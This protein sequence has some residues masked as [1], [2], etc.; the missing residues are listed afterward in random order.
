MSPTLDGICTVSQNVP[1]GLTVSIVKCVFKKKRQ[2]RQKQVSILIKFHRS[3]F[4]RVELTSQ[5]H[6]IHYS[7]LQLQEKRLNAEI[8]QHIHYNDAI[9][10]AM[11]SQITSLA[12]VY[13]IVY[14][15]ADQ[16]KHQSSASLAFV[17]GIHRWPVNSPHKWPVTQKMWR[18]YL[19]WVYDLAQPRLRL[20]GWLETLRGFI[21][22]TDLFQYWYQTLKPRQ[23]WHRLA[24]D[25]FKCNFVSANYCIL[26]Q[27]SLK[28]F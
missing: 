22:I 3:L 6:T 18:T 21:S 16:R 27:F 23:K 7:I 9:M 28:F 24:D 14:S 25:I 2:N 19:N 12:I 1:S 26:I 20:S 15:D 17:R 5:H 8:Y 10:G 4:I 13:S 11:A